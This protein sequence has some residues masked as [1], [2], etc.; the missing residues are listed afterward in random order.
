MTQQ[1]LDFTQA[2]P[3]AVKAMYA[4]EA[5]IAKLG[6]EHALL[7]LIRL[8]ASQINGC[9]FCVDMHTSDA[10][11]AGETERRLYA[12]SVWRETPFFTPRERAVLAW[13][14]ALTL[15]PQNH[16]SDEDYAALAQQLT[17]AEMV[18]VTLAIGSINTWNRLAVGFRKMPE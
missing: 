4:L 17:P 5:A 10:R 1:R 6:V 2:S 3:D 18:N 11:K 12:V 14:E 8:R 13:T 16:A 7:E 9:A 15:L